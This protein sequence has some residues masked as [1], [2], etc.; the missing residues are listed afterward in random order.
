M[1]DPDIMEQEFEKDICIDC[2]VGI[3]KP[4]P[5]Q[6]HPFFMAYP[7]SLCLRCNE[8]WRWRGQICKPRP[9]QVPLWRPKHGNCNS[10]S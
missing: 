4:K 3:D 9:Y 7:L 5:V 2:G 6:I 10:R 8:S 1:N